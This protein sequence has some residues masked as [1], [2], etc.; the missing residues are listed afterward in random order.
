MY[1]RTS[2]LRR[3]SKGVS[4]VIATILLVAITVVLAATLY[5][6]VIGF[7]GDT[8][9]NIPP[10]GDIVPAT[11]SGGME[12][13]FTQLSKNTVW[14]DIMILISDGN[15]NSVF[16]NI[17]TD[18]LDTG[19]PVT[20]SFGSRDLGNLKVFLNVSDLTGN[21]YVSGGDYITLTTGDGNFSHITTYEVTVIH[22]PSDSRIVST[23]FQGS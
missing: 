18:A 14:G 20:A 3:D 21:G 4:P 22:N 6:M 1:L 12:F 13:T 7:G 17:T 16:S 23:T 10:V 8:G 15:N 2:C 11:I 19:T 5:Y 9:S